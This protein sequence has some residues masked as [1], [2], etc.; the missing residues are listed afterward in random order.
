MD[1]GRPVQS[2]TTS[3]QMKMKLKLLTVAILAGLSL[4][5]LASNK[6]PLTGNATNHFTITGMH[7]D[8]CAGGLTAEL[9]ETPGVASATV[10]FSNKLAVVSYDTNKITKAKLT[11][12]I[13]EAGFTAK[14]TNPPRVKP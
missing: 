13:K 4:N 14:E 9:K 7:C 1:A 6:P 10:T 11:A 2:L 5:S 12:A 3:H 8:G